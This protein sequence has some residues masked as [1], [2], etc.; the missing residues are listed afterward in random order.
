[1]KETTDKNL[2][3]RSAYAPKDIEVKV[4]KFYR[5]TYHVPYI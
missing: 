5:G 1:M 2:I 3:W 4:H